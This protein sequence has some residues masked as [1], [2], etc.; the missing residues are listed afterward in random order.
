MHALIRFAWKY[1]VDAKNDKQVQNACGNLDEDEDGMEQEEMWVDP[2]QGLGTAKREWGGPTRG[3]RLPE[4]TR[5][6]DWERKGRCSDFWMEWRVIGIGAI[7]KFDTCMDDMYAFLVHLNMR[8]LCS[9]HSCLTLLLP[10]ELSDTYHSLTAFTRKRYTLTKLHL[11]FA[12][13]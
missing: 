13:G 8:Q 12:L 1:Q 7:N 10:Y 6:G 5:Y 11:I 9:M 4:P 3:G 2:A